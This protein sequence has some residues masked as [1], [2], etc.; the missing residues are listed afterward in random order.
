MTLR[1][2]FMGTPDFA[3]PTLSE[4][5]QGLNETSKLDLPAR[6]AD[7]YQEDLEGVPA[8]LERQLARTDGLAETIEASRG[9]E[10]LAV[11]GRGPNYATAF[12]AALKIKELTG[13]V[14]EPA[15]PA[16]FLHGPVAVLEP[17]FPVLALYPDSDAM[18][19][20]L[21]T[22]RER[23]ADITVIGERADGRLLA[24]PNRADY[25]DLQLEDW[26]LLPVE[27]ELWHGFVFVRLE[28]EGPSVAE[29]MAPYEDEIAPYRFEDMRALGRVVMRPR[30]VTIRRSSLR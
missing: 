14:A 13:M 23:E 11:I 17:G 21:A 27:C 15:S 29:M 3:V 28:S 5:V 7:V 24:V 12:E 20:V 10:R 16:D 4:I 19:D 1:V 9:W 25:G 18:R 26:G 2:V 22:A 6:L 30:T 8:A